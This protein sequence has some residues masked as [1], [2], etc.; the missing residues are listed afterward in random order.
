MGPGKMLPFV[1]EVICTK[2]GELLGARTTI[3]TGDEVLTAPALS[4]A[5]ANSVYSPGGTLDQVNA[6]P[7]HSIDGQRVASNTPIPRNWVP[8][9]NCTCKSN[10]SS[11][12]VA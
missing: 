1:G 12:S 2:G 10:P 5:R 7:G 6:K 8:T 11:W 4:V 9:K 3:L